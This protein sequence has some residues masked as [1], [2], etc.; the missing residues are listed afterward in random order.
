MAQTRLP[1]RRW[2]I[3]PARPV[4]TQEKS[5][6]RGA[7]SDE[8]GAF[9]VKGPLPTCHILAGS[10][11][12]GCR[13]LRGW[14]DRS[15][16]ARALLDIGVVARRIVAV[17][18]RGLAT[19]GRVRVGRVGT[20][21]GGPERF[22]PDADSWAAKPMETSVEA[23][24]E[25][26]PTTPRKS[27]PCACQEQR[28][29]HNDHPHP[30]LPSSHRDPFLASPCPCPATRDLP[31]HRERRQAH[32]ASPTTDLPGNRPDASYIVPRY[33][34]HCHSALVTTSWYMAT[35]RRKM[36]HL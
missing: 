12:E 14:G 33:P 34:W 35:I 21:V 7:K 20:P 24:V 32:H 4:W 6:Q 11:C 29:Q 9:V 16:A 23:M 8:T 25:A 2:G 19:H 30:L 36:G 10:S 15:P 26:V 28:R 22:N 18:P 17:I 13:R 1:L 5:H 3:Q 27:W 31:R